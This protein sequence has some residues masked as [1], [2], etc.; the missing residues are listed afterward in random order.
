MARRNN[1]RKKPSTT[2]VRSFKRNRKIYR[3]FA[4]LT[5]SFQLSCDKYFA[6]FGCWG[7]GCKPNSGQ[8]LVAN[9]INRDPEIK[10]IVSTG[11]NIYEEETG[12]P[13]FENFFH[14]N[15]DICYEKPM[16]AALGN[17]DVQYIDKQINYNGGNWH[18]PAR[19]YMIN[20]NDNIRVFVVDT[21][22]LIEGTRTYEK[23]I[24]PVEAAKAEYRESLK[25]FRTFVGDMVAEV[26]REKKFTI[27]VGHHP[28]ITNRH[29]EKAKF[30]RKT[31]ADLEEEFQT[32]LRLCD[33]YVCADE[34]NLQHLLFEEEGE[35]PRLNQFI[36][37]GGGGSPDEIVILDY[38]EET[39]FVHRYHGY[40]IF[41]VRDLSLTLRCLDKK[42]K[43]FRYEYR[44]NN[45]E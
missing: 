24:E 25:E 34:H 21:N 27:C 26:H 35:G 15:V 6:L 44:F 16:Y 12:T 39:K 42:T 18:L 9:D 45:A 36:V 41:D 2:R 14:E 1:A 4:P 11:D 38:P 32:I 23:H 33:M 7:K 13:D 43:S 40:G 5:P 30:S 8:K 22:P 10:F 3:S 17:H 29:K 28:M 37:G 19:N 31:P 20:I